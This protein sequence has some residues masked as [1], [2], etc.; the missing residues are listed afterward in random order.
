MA[1]GNRSKSYTAHQIGAFIALLV[2]VIWGLAVL[3]V[4]MVTPAGADVFE[5][6]Y[7]GTLTLMFLI[8]LPLYWKR[9][10]WAYIGGILMVVAMYAGAAKVALDQDLVF[11]WSLYNMVTILIYAIALAC[12]YFSVRSYRE[13]ASFGTKKTI[14]GIGSIVVAT[15]IVAAVLWSNRGLVQ[16]TMWQFT[17]DRIGN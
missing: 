12:V 10:R 6:T 14:L 7:L 13:L 11:S 5:M 3:W 2:L 4:H 16:R 9:V 17:L 1:S 8:L 15:A